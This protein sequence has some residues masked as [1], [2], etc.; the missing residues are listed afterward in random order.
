[1]QAVVD[2]AATVA[3]MH[4]V[5]VTLSYPGDEIGID[6]IWLA[7]IDGASDVPTSKAGRL[8]R[9]DIYTLTWEIRTTDHGDA[10]AAMLRVEALAAV[11]DGMLA[12]DSTLGGL[13]GLLWATYGGMDRG[14]LPVQ[15]PTGFIGFGEFTIAAHARLT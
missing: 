2:L 10:A 11:V 4:N 8:Q 1:M 13:D 12:D 9:D 6:A 15:T 3:G 5:G 7:R 14:P